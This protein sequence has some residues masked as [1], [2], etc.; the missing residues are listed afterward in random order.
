M[1]SSPVDRRDGLVEQNGYRHDFS[2]LR[3]ARAQACEASSAVQI[4]RHTVSRVLQRGSDA[5]QSR[6]F[7][8][9]GE[10]LL[11]SGALATCPLLG[12]TVPSHD[13]LE[14]F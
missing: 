14:A 7:L 9:H 10:F 1:R 3:R 6:P 5:Q 11:S 4:A 8:L 13:I 2:F 12:R